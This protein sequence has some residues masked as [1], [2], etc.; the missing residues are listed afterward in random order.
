MIKKQKELVKKNSKSMKIID[1]H[2]LMLLILGSINLLS[3]LLN[4]INN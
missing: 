3:T 4:Y 2:L 1:C